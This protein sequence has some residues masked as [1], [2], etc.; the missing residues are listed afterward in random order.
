MKPCPKCQRLLQDDA[1]FC[2]DDGASLK[3]VGAD[4]LLGSVVGDRYILVEKI[5]DGRSGVIYRGEHAVLRN[6]LAVKLLNHQASKNKSLINRFQE[7]V[8]TIA[9]IDSEHVVRVS[10]F[11][12]VPDGR[13]FFTMEFL[14]GESLNRLLEKEGRLLED[15]GIRLFEQIGEALSEA[16]AVGVIHGEVCP[17][18]IFIVR[19][20]NREV[21]KLLD[22]GLAKLT[23]SRPVSKEERERESL[24]DPKY[25]S[26]EQAKG[27]AIDERTDIYS[28]AVLAYEMVMGEAP[29]D[30]KTAFDVLTKHLEYQP[31]PVRERVSEV[32]AAFSGAIARALNKNPD[33]RFDTIDEFIDAAFGREPSGKEVLQHVESIQ[34][35]PLGATLLGIGM[36]DD[37]RSGKTPK[38]SN[39]VGD[40]S[41]VKQGAEWKASLADK[42]QPEIVG[43]KET[44]RA[45]TLPI[46]VKLPSVDSEISKAE[47]KAALGAVGTERD[48]DK[49]KA[50]EKK[51][52]VN[53]K[54]RDETRTPP[55]LS[56][57]HPTVKELV[58]SGEK[59]ET[60]KSSE[61]SG[62]GLEG[63]ES[64]NWFAE[65]LEAERA[66]GQ[67]GQEGKP[68]PRLY[69]SLED[70]EFGD[71]KR[72]PSA[73]KVLVW[74]IGIA[75]IC[76]AGLYFALRKDAEK[77]EATT[78]QIERKEAKNEEVKSIK[79]PEA[80]TIES[81]KPIAPPEEKLA[82]EPTELPKSIE[83]AKTTE[84]LKL[85]E[86]AKPKVLAN[87]TK[88]SKQKVAI[89]SQKSAWAKVEN[90]SSK[91]MWEKVATKPAEQE[92]PKPAVEPV[93]Q[94]EPKTGAEAAQ[95]TK[96]K[97]E[98]ISRAKSAEKD[99]AQAKDRV[100]LGLSYLQKGSHSKAKIEFEAALELDV[101]NSAALG[102]LGEVAFEM[103]NYS[104]ATDYL[105][106]ALQIKPRQLKYRVMLGNVYFKQ[107]RTKLAVDQYQSAL[108]ID[109]NNAEALSA[110]RAAMRRL[111]DES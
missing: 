101:R 104:Q 16:H 62:A 5:G 84:Q 4:P 102:G 43:G 31:V 39:N 88:Q 37:L 52:A 92:K 85:T 18:N 48:G 26:P 7:E 42:I 79:S 69:E 60:G 83:P 80:K 100:N 22:L 28:L 2:P 54:L 110:M 34:T 89:A 36:P 67:A 103:G 109:P 90:K 111:A 63:V 32:S 49:E 30:G 13:L 57:E 29:F 47:E 73:S 81:Q 76:V 106:K 105:K 86:S 3:S 23:S 78:G 74:V 21:V 12:R 24:L 55:W 64:G 10:D 107:G 46:H 87:I 40:E 19:K 65:G 45:K 35:K 20:K 61:G 72:G 50:A 94:E 96:P 97:V 77:P 91:P 41:R 66:L 17:R 8:A 59:A 99:L 33:D 68:L 51:L 14:E 1:E 15:R 25:M 9:Q 71:L 11:G 98:A 75:A 44:V 38:G 58:Q 27:E 82:A 56:V 93:K 95:K 53:K 108:E 70:S 6:K